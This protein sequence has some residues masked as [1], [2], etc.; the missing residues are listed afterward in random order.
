MIAL[1]AEVEELQ[2][3]ARAAA[4]GTV[5]EAQLEVGRGPVASVIVQR[6]MLKKG[7]AIVAGPVAGRVRAMFDDTGAEVRQAGPSSP[8]LVMGWDDVPTAGD[9]FEVVKNERTARKMAESTSAEIRAAELTVPSAT[10]RLGM[11]I[12]QLRTDVEQARTLLIDIA[13]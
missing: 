1:V 5:I 13:D 7:D 6:G 3:N 9:M 8:V 11:L 10:D 12:E 2:A 4:I